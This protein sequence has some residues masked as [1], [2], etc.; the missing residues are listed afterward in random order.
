MYIPYS[1]FEVHT[2]MCTLCIPAHQDLSFTWMSML[3]CVPACS[4]LS[5]H[6]SF[7]LCVFPIPLPIFFC[8]PLSLVSSD[9][10]I[11]HRSDDVMPCPQV[12]TCYP[13]GSVTS[14]LYILCCYSRVRGL[15]V[16]HKAVCFEMMNC[17]LLF[18]TSGAAD[19]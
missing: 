7:P 18:L 4:V 6:P 15:F 14:L 17:H 1:R 12:I 3:V 9:H 10:V 8:I 2:Q 13:A 5:L 19:T 16:D 11:P